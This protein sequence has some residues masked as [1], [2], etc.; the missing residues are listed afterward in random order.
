MS[1]VGVIAGALTRAAL[2]TWGS[3]AASL[4][5]SLSAAAGVTLAAA[6]APLTSPQGRAPFDTRRYITGLRRAFRDLFTGASFLAQAVN[7]AVSTVASATAALVSNW[8]TIVTLV[9]ISSLATYAYAFSDFNL[10][11][12]VA[13]HAYVLYPIAFAVNSI[14]YTVVSAWTWGSPFL[15]ASWRFLLAGG[16]AVTRLF[17]SCSQMGVATLTTQLGVLGVA[18]A[19]DLSVGSAATLD[20][21][22][23]MGAYWDVSDTAQEIVNT[24]SASVDVADCMCSAASPVVSQLA[25]LTPGPIED[26]LSGA[27]T[28]VTGGATATLAAAVSGNAIDLQ[29]PIEA[30][31]LAVDGGGRLVDDVVRASVLE[32][33]N[34]ILGLGGIGYDPASFQLFGA[35]SAVAASYINAGAVV[36]GAIGNAGSLDPFDPAI[37]TQIDTSAVLAAQLDAAARIGATFDGLIPELGAFVGKSGECYARYVN[38]YTRAGVTAGL[39]L[40][41]AI[42]DTWPTH[43]VPVLD[44]ADEAAEAAGD[45]VTVLT[46]TADLPT[47]TGTQAGRNPIG[48]LVTTFSHLFLGAVRYTLDAGV[49]SVDIALPDTTTPYICTAAHQDMRTEV[50]SRVADI[51]DLTACLGAIGG[52]G[53]SFGTI[54][55]CPNPPVMFQDSTIVPCSV[56]QTATLSSNTLSPLTCSAVIT[57]GALGMGVRSFEEFTRLLE[58]LLLRAA[59]AASGDPFPT[60]ACTPFGILETDAVDF[61]GFNSELQT[62]FQGVGC[63]V[64]STMAPLD[65]SGGERIPCLVTAGLEF[66][67]LLP[68]E[69]VDLALSGGFVDFFTP[70]GPNVAA[71]TDPAAVTFA[72]IFSLVQARAVALLRT[73]GLFLDAYGGAG[74]GFG[75]LADFLEVAFPPE[76]MASFVE[77]F[78]SGLQVLVS[79]LRLDGSTSG[80][81]DF[82]TALAQ[83]ITTVITKLGDAAYSVFI[84][85][86][87]T[88]L[89]QF[90][91]AGA[92]AASFVFN[93]G[94][95]LSNA[96]CGPLPRAINAIFSAFN[97]VVGAVEGLC[98][99]VSSC[100]LPRL[101]PFLPTCTAN[102]SWC[103]PDLF[104]FNRFV[105]V[106]TPPGAENPGGRAQCKE[107]VNSEFLGAS[108]LGDKQTDVTF[109]LHTAVIAGSVYDAEC[110]PYNI[111]PIVSGQF[112]P[113][114]YMAIYRHSVST[115]A[116][117]ITA[118]TAKLACT[119][120][121]MLHT[122]GGPVA[123][124]SVYHFDNMLYYA[125]TEDVIPLTAVPANPETDPYLG[126]AEQTTLNDL[127]FWWGESNAADEPG[128]EFVC[129]ASGWLT[130]IGCTSNAQCEADWNSLTGCTNRGFTPGHESSTEQTCRQQMRTLIMPSICIPEFV[131]TAAG[132]RQVGVCSTAMNPMAVPRVL[133]DWQ[134]T[135]AN[136]HLYNQLLLSAYTGFF[137]TCTQVLQAGQNIYLQQIPGI[138]TGAA[139][140]LEAQVHSTNYATACAPPVLGTPFEECNAH[141]TFFGSYWFRTLS[142][143]AAGSASSIAAAIIGKLPTASL[144]FNPAPEREA[145]TFAPIFGYPYFV[146]SSSAP[147][148]A[149][150]FDTTLDP[151]CEQVLFSAVMPELNA[152]SGDVQTNCPANVA[153]VA[154]CFDDRALFDGDVEDVDPAPVD[155]AI[156]TDKQFTSTG[157][158]RARFRWDYDARINAATYANILAS[159]AAWGVSADWTSINP[160]FLAQINT[161]LRDNAVCVTENIQSGHFMQGYPI[162]GVEVTIDDAAFQTA[163]EATTAIVADTNAGNAFANNPALDDWPIGGNGVW[164][165]PRD[166]WTHTGRW[167]LRCSF[168]EVSGTNV[169]PGGG[170]AGTTWSNDWRLT[171]NYGFRGD[172]TRDVAIADPSRLFA[173]TVASQQSFG[174]AL[175]RASVSPTIDDTGMLSADEP[176]APPAPPMRNEPL[177][178]QIHEGAWKVFDG[179]MD[180]ARSFVVTLTEHRGELAP[181]CTHVLDV[182]TNNTDFG[183]HTAIGIFSCAALLPDVQDELAKRGLPVDFSPILAQAVLESLSV[184][185]TWTPYTRCGA[186]GHDLETKPLA[187]WTHLERHDLRECVLMRHATGVIGAA[188][189][190]PSLPPDFLTDRLDTVWV[191]ITAVNVIRN[192]WK[193]NETTWEVMEQIRAGGDRLA[194]EM[195]FALEQLDVGAWWANTTGSVRMGVMDFLDVINAD[196][197]AASFLREATNFVDRVWYAYTIFRPHETLLNT[198]LPGIGSLLNNAWGGAINITRELRARHRLHNTTTVPPPESQSTPTGGVLD[199]AVV[200]AVGESMYELFLATKW[201]YEYRYPIDSAVNLEIYTNTLNG[202]STGITVPTHVDAA[203]VAAFPVLPNQNSFS[204]LATGSPDSVAANIPPLPTPAAGQSQLDA[205][206]PSLA[207]GKARLLEAGSF[208]FDDD[209]YNPAIALAEESGG[210]LGNAAST[211]ADALSTYLDFTVSFEIN[212]PSLECDYGAFYGTTPERWTERQVYWGAIAIIV[213]G[214]LVARYMSF[215]TWIAFLVY[216]V[217]GAGGVMAIAWSLQFGTSGLCFAPPPR[218]GTFLYRMLAF[219]V[220]PC[221]EVPAARV[222]SLA[223]DTPGSLCVLPGTD[224]RPCFEING[225]GE[226]LTVFFFLFASIGD[227]FSSG[228]ATSSFDTAIATIAYG[229][230]D[231]LTTSTLGFNAFAVA[232]GTPAFEAALANVAAARA[233]TAVSD[234]PY[235]CLYDQIFMIALLAISIPAAAAA[236]IARTAVTLAGA[237]TLPVV[238]YSVSTF[239]E[240]LIEAGSM[241]AGAM[242]DLASGIVDTVADDIAEQTEELARR[243]RPNADRRRTARA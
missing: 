19:N 41:F 217:L 241:S 170:Y 35:A 34:S 48:A 228:V 74:R 31:G 89:Q 216:S 135:T 8:Q 18:L 193:A 153:H 3:M 238:T 237:T 127:I 163:C 67:I 113:A 39:G 207:Q 1:G 148:N 121:N 199:C 100:S 46:A 151:L 172:G 157:C 168:I 213:G 179:I 226:G 225:M 68:L 114:N 152:T 173:E 87:G 229:I 180:I 60:A 40:D 104:A 143:T 29:H 78:F 232:F 44:C 86:I 190:V 203:A 146:C 25:M 201:Y 129:T 209:A 204:L 165:R 7:A 108:N 196:P 239:M 230:F 126:Y 37:A 43:G 53:G 176:F 58:T 160:A 174:G 11:F 101:G 231:F 5:F 63:L 55:E 185:R 73:A 56:D 198:T 27:L 131:Y 42:T 166:I 75:D 167:G 161:L 69:I 111:Q 109:G 112:T 169:V 110:G 205:L 178:K 22:I 240:T 80:P 117:T 220:P 123:P 136:G 97:W 84:H 119:L 191:G 197:E 45:L 194:F 132:Y 144:T 36:A 188:L 122:A 222:A 164:S 61:A 85:L 30:A 215:V 115:I 242:E 124:R 64:G 195:A 2:V 79:M 28:A 51:A 171:S 183:P 33:S 49:N 227:Y 47:C 105:V 208:F 21:S 125:D 76:A 206:F 81:D 17:V 77:I 118:W 214:M 54:I 52:G 236:I 120:P 223:A 177:S 10:E 162:V 154:W 187:T 14:L 24:V 138:T 235:E 38:A 4:M 139:V 141:R 116:P 32:A 59:L 212:F 107:S 72:R 210:L 133:Y 92:D 98:R 91:S 150:K 16:F 147:R 219:T 202:V 181:D 142:S 128:E 243:Q 71:G 221:Y 145:F 200:H 65:A 140:G 233:F 106:S 66:T 88:F 155:F 137:S 96:L 192:M 6:A 82:A 94:L 50:F 224:L 189:G 234:A 102:P 134:G 83:L 13:L 99:I 62:V 158:D 186:I 130:R 156:V 23:A 12:R 70:G 182:A 93:A 149:I 175:L 20:G 57:E 159:L 95:C 9:A 26:I 218:L 90:G 184:S 211:I 15:Y 103:A